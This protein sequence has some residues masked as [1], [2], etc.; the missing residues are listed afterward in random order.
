M[1]TEVLNY[2]SSTSTDDSGNI[3]EFSVVGSGT[4]QVPVNMQYCM[5]SDVTPT[6]FYRNYVFVIMNR[7]GQS[8]SSVSVI[9]KQ[10]LTNYPVPNSP[11]STTFYLRPTISNNVANSAGGAYDITSEEPNPFVLG[12]AVFQVNLAAVP[13]VA[14]TIDWALIGY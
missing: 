11:T 4:I 2:A 12:K 8:A 10:L 7:T 14:G 1:T 5:T 9:G 3:R 6:K 13:T